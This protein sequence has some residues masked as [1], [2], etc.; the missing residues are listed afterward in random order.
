MALIVSPIKAAP[1]KLSR[2]MRAGIL[3]VKELGRDE[4]RDAWRFIDF[5]EN[6]ALAASIIS[7]SCSMIIYS[8]VL[9]RS[10]A[11]QFTGWS[12]SG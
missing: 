7:I 10:S 6:L 5:R 9:R 3:M 12:K 2:G 4:A 11:L 1:V 8:H